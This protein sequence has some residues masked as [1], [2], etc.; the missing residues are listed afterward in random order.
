MAGKGI[1]RAMRGD[2]EGGGNP[3]GIGSG[4]GKSH[5]MAFEKRVR[6]GNETPS[7]NSGCKPPEQSRL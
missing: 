2:V 6:R 5:H 4:S 7:K 3:I 1:K